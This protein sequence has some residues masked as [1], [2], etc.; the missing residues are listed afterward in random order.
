MISLFSPTYANIATRSF[1]DDLPI[2][3]NMVTLSKTR[4]IDG[5]RRLTSIGH[6]VKN[7]DQLPLGKNGKMRCYNKV[8]WELWRQTI[9]IILHP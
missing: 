4:L 1:V 3:T 5:Q 8:C 6:V 7:F 9:Y 2:L